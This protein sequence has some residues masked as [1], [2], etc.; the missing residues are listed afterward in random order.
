MLLDIYKYPYSPLHWLQ[1]FLGER[2]DHELHEPGPFRRFPNSGIIMGK[3]E[4]PTSLYSKWACGYLCRTLR[5]IG[6]AFCP[7]MG[8]P[9]HGSQRY[10]EQC[11]K[12]LC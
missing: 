10:K 3:Q 6:C 1:L 4:Y 2:M 5:E 12:K 7:V 11:E 8:V 9:M